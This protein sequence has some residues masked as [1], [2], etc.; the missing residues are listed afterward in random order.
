MLLRSIAKDVAYRGDDL[1]Q[2]SADYPE[3]AKY[4]DAVEINGASNQLLHSLFVTW[5]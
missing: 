5:P 1:K 2:F 3:L 4:M